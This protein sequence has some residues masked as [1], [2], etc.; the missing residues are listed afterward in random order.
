MNKKTIIC[1]T[2]FAFV[3]SLTV[4]GGVSVASNAGPAEMVLKTAKGKKPANFPHKKHQD[5]LKC[6]ECHH[7]KTADG[8]QGPYVAGKEGKCESCHDGKTIA[9]QKVA[10]FMKAAHTNCKG[11]HK[12]KKKGPTKCNDCHI[13]K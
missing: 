11:C 12:D 13:K 4:A 7:T 10:N 6:D 9:N 5:M 1:A 8:K 2:A 3:F